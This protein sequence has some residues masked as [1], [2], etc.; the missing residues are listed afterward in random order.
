[1]KNPKFFNKKPVENRITKIRNSE[2]NYDGLN[3]TE[4]QLKSVIKMAYQ[5]GYA[6][7]PEEYAWAIDLDDGEIDLTD[8]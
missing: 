4:G 2:I 3:I 1:M 5:A 7:D 8:E 6:V